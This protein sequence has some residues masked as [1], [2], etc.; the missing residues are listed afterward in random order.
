MARGTGPVAIDAERASGYR[1]SARAYLIQLRR[2]GS[3]TFLVDPIAVRLDGAAAGGPRGHRVDPARRDPGP[4][5]PQRGRPV[6]HAALR[7]RARRPPARPPA[8]RAGHAGRDPARLPDGQGALGRGLVDPAAARSRGSSTPPSTSRCSS[9]CAR[10]SAPS[11]SRPARTA[12]P[13]RSSSGC[14]T[15]TQTV[16]VDQWRRTSGLHKVRGRRALG[17]VR[18]LWTTRDQIAAER[19][20]TPSRIIPDSAIVAA[21][22]AMPTTR[23][24]PQGHQGL[25]RPRRRPV[26]RPLGRRADPGTRPARGPAAD[27]DA[28]LRRAAAAARLGRQGP[29]RRPASAAGPRGDH[30]HVRGAEGPRREPA[31]ARLR[32]P[33]AVDPAAVARPRA[34]HPGDLGRAARHGRPRV[35]GPADRTAAGRRR[36]GGRRGGC[37]SR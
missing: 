37:R 27:A 35:A 7:H 9:S 10:C 12:G 30:R 32:A 25:L 13:P 6:P 23:D 29:G 4:A 3:G 24:G 33:R 16:R 2:E 31:H 17:A 8:R 15:F 28:A 18:A 36:A 14:K 11:W 1:Y 34:A 19:D 26:R 20:V 5:L 22:L 21:A